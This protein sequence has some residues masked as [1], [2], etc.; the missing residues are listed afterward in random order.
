MRRR[1]GERLALGV[2]TPTDIM[3]R[4][5]MNIMVP[6][7]TSIIGRP[8]TNVT[9][10]HFQLL[11]PRDFS[12]RMICLRTL[13]QHQRRERP[14]G[15]HNRR[16]VAVISSDVEG[17]RRTARRLGRQWKRLHQSARFVRSH[18]CLRAVDIFDKS[19]ERCDMIPWCIRSVQA[20]S[21]FSDLV[22]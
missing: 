21:F 5:S 2:R 3:V 20:F 13:N 22:C 19:Y 18:P 15:R 16:K 14:Q 17:H 9:T 12:Q 7:R 6:L 11:R 4:L 10:R 8:P 1:L